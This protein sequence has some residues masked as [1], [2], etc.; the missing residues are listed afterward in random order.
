MKK[1]LT[2][3]Q[4]SFMW[5]FFSSMYWCWCLWNNGGLADSGCIF[6]VCVHRTGFHFPSDLAGENWGHGLQSRRAEIFVEEWIS[7]FCYFNAKHS[8]ISQNN[9]RSVLSHQDSAKSW[10]ILVNLV[11]FCWTQQSTT[12]PRCVWSPSQNSP[13]VKAWPDQNITGIAV[14]C[15]PDCSPIVFSS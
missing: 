3:Y 8:L 5:Y 11:N 2:K 15:R 10:G 14:N 12:R 1:L 7:W 9:I 13:L 4:V 6:P